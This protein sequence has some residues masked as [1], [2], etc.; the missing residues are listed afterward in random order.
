MRFSWIITSVTN[1][2][3]SKPYN[4]LLIWRKNDDSTPF[5][6][7]DTIEREEIR[8]ARANTNPV[9]M[10]HDRIYKDVCLEFP[11]TGDIVTVMAVREKLQLVGAYYSIVNDCESDAY[12]ILEIQKLRSSINGNG[13]SL[14]NVAVWE[15]EYDYT[16]ELQEE[17][18]RVH[19]FD[20]TYLNTSEDVFLPNVNGEP[21]LV[22]INVLG[23]GNN[24]SSMHIH[25]EFKRIY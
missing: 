16:P 18:Y 22:A 23:S 6:S 7:S 5:N 2:F 14:T 9:L 11:Q 13:C 4:Q 24:I 25:L 21:D 20:P 1:L 15:L 17:R 19:P 8:L 12:V 10:A 3:S